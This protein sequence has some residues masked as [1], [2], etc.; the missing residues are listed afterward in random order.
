MP[1][2]VVADSKH[3]RCI[4]FRLELVEI[5][6]SEMDVGNMDGYECARTGEGY[7]LMSCLEKGGQVAEATVHCAMWMHHAVVGLVAQLDHGDLHSLLCESLHHTVDPTGHRFLGLV[8]GQV[9]PHLR[10]DLL[11]RVCPRVAKMKVD[12]D[13]HPGLLHPLCFLDDARK[14]VI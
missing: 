2:A 10:G 12:E 14:G 13:V 7:S 4:A 9:S 11:P 8:K 3:I 6:G 1:K 5:P